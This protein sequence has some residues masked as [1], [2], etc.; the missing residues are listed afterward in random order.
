[1]DYVTSQMNPLQIIITQFFQ[2][3]RNLDP[4]TLTNIPSESPS[5]VL[6][7]CH[8]RNGGDGNEEEN[9]SH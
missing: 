4:F 7:I 9:C 8:I 2:K 1:M 3:H 5:V 6:P